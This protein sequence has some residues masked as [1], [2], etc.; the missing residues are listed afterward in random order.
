VDVT[1][2]DQDMFLVFAVAGEC[3]LLA[4]LLSP[5]GWHRHVIRRLAPV[6]SRLIFYYDGASYVDQPVLLTRA[7]DYWNRFLRSIGGSASPHPVFGIVGS[8]DCDL[9]AVP[10]SELAGSFK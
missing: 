8:P 7:N 3:R 5:Q 1:A 9:D 2:S 4:A 10:W 6:G